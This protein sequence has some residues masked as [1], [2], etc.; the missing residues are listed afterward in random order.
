MHTNNLEQLTVFLYFI[1]IGAILGVV[2]DI[3]RILRRTVKTSDIMTNIQDILFGFITG[4]IILISIFF[5]NNGEL[6][7]FLFIGMIVGTTIY[8]LFVSKYFINLNVAIINFIKKIIILITK[9]FIII[10]KF[11]KKVFFKPF[12]FIFINIKLILKKVC[13]IFKKTTKINKKSIKEE[14]F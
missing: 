5:L 7:L 1:L 10:L 13:K 4:S 2:F 12:S 3:F 11:I 8:M 14:G 6:R 9:P